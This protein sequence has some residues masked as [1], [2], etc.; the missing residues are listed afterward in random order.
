MTTESRDVCLAGCGCRRVSCPRSWGR[1]LCVCASQIR[2]C[3]R[4]VRA[5][6]AGARL[7]GRPLSLAQGTAPELL[8]R[9]SV[10]WGENQKREQQRTD[11][12]K[13]NL[14]FKCYRTQTRQGQADAKR[15][16]QGHSA[17]LLKCPRDSCHFF[18]HGKPLWWINK[19]R[20]QEQ[21]TKIHNFMSRTY[22]FCEL[23]FTGH[24]NLLWGQWTMELQRPHQASLPSGCTHGVVDGEE[25]GAPQEDPRLA[26]TLEGNE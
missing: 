12:T 9:T 3:A 4:R 16:V 10:S 21:G 5:G 26:H 18:F 22:H 6:V 23:I 13:I 20:P 2:T 7:L 17:L 14:F 1:A 8:P 25:H 11:D 19:T 24:S 15:Q